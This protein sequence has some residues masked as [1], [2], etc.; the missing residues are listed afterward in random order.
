MYLTVFATNDGSILIKRSTNFRCDVSLAKPALT[1]IFCVSITVL[2]GNNHG[3]QAVVVTL[4]ADP[5][6]FGVSLSD[7]LLTNNF[8][9]SQPF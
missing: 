8:H 3:D 1:V 7:C 5:Y 6:Q 2:L 9:S 4:G